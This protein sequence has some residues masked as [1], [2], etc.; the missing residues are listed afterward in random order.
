MYW[1]KITGFYYGI[2][3][4]TVSSV[5]F[6]TFIIN[7]FLRLLR[8]SLRLLWNIL[9]FALAIY[10]KLYWGKIYCGNSE[11]YSVFSIKSKYG[12]IIF[13]KMIQRATRG[14]KMR[15]GL[16][17][18]SFIWYRLYDIEFRPTG[19][20]RYLFERQAASFEHNLSYA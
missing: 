2:S 10:F 20:V 8:W 9:F 17:S 12:H 18:F 5:C 4:D 19:A 1:R 11:F 7:G 16:K 15:R 6:L 14:K 3:H 13:L